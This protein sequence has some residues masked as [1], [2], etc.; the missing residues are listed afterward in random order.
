MWSA[1]AEL[2]QPR[3][4]TS[5]VTT[6]FDLHEVRLLDFI[7]RLRTARWRTRRGHVSGAL[8]G[9]ASSDVSSGC[10]TCQ[11]AIRAVRTSPTLQ[12]A[13]RDEHAE[14]QL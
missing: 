10:A 9:A 8:A 3:D 14:I 4:R 2:I 5:T 6:G 1:P 12:H 11:N 13:L 7:G